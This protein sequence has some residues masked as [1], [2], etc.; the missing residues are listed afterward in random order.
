MLS[1][2]EETIAAAISMQLLGEELH[3]EITLV[4]ECSSNFL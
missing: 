3:L 4:A 2:T 1:L